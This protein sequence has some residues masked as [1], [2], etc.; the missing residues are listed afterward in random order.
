MSINWSK[1][2]RVYCCEC[3][4]DITHTPLDV[5]VCA[6]CRDKRKAELHRM[7]MVYGPRP[8]ETRGRKKKGAA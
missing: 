7:L 1:L 4:A 6:A 2:P 8:A 3:G 5:T